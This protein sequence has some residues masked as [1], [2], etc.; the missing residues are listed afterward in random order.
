VF[1]AIVLGYDGDP[2][3]VVDRTLRFLDDAEVDALQLTILT[4]FPGTPL[5]RRL[6][7]E[8]RIVDRDWEHYDLGHVVFRPA[9]VGTDELR[10]GHDRILAEFYSWRWILR[11]LRRQARYLRPGELGLSAAISWGYRLKTRLDGYVPSA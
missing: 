4:P 9:S 6:E 2:A 10:S 8:G 1:G 3:D 5:H 7:A 11:R